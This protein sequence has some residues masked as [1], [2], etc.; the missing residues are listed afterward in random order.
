MLKDEVGVSIRP[1]PIWAWDG[2]QATVASVAGNLRPI[3]PLPTH[4]GQWLSGLLVL[5][6]LDPYAENRIERL[7]AG[8]NS[9]GRLSHPGCRTGF[10]FLNFYLLS[11]RPI[12][13]KAEDIRL[14]P[15]RAILDLVS[16][17]PE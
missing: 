14:C 12:L 8:L 16:T 17:R 5:R 9:A 4:V 2:T 13:V 3:L 7:R 1:V 6:S 11:A 15:C 10:L